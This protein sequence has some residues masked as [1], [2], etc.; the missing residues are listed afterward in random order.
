LEGEVDQR[1]RKQKIND[2]MG[3]ERKQPRYID[4]RILQQLGS[5]C[6]IAEEK[7]MG[8]CGRRTKCVE[9]R[10]REKRTKSQSVHIET[11]FLTPSIPRKRKDIYLTGRGESDIA[12]KKRKT[13]GGLT[14]TSLEIDS[15]SALGRIERSTRR[16]DPYKG[17]SSPFDAPP[18]AKG[19]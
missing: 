16:G 4:D 19:S 13:P 1:E 3:G 11:S 5:R 6:E 18:D 2:K 10:R 12:P 7:K 8:G 14:A 15:R 17:T 9:E